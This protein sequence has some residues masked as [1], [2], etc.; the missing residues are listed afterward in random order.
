IE[1]LK[2]ALSNYQKDDGEALFS[3]IEGLFEGNK[4]S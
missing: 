4:Q 3:I 2:L 1:E